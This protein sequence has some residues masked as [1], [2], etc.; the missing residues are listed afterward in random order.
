MGKEVGAE[1]HCAEA[2]L[3]QSAG[4]IDGLGSVQTLARRS[5]AA[6]RSRAISRGP[7]I[8]ES[9]TTYIMPVIR[10]KLQCLC[11]FYLKYCTW[12]SVVREVII[13]RVT[14]FIGFRTDIVRS[15]IF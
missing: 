6:P 9:A 7:A 11:R 5:M 10:T 4:S 8:S 2:K 1:W 3:G 14:F 15:T 12:P 13:S